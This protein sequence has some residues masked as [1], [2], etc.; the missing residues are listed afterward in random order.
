MLT[1][2]LKVING[3]PEVL[4]LRKSTPTEGP[5]GPVNAREFIVE[6]TV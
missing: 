1:R 5:N 4:T 2:V 6:A 3:Q